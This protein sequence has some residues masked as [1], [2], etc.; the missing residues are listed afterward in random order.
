M[1]TDEAY[2]QVQ[3]TTDSEDDARRIASTVVGERLAACAQLLAP[4]TSVYW[5][6]GAV[7]EAKEWLC[8]LKTTRD[9]YP[10]LE[11][12][13]RELHSYEEPEI[14]A[15]RLAAGSRG[16]LDWIRASTGPAEEAS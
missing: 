6:D 3:T 13:L 2:L 4:V 14:V 8:L 12:R 9:R 5:W 10:A 1:S 11:A 16:Y 7:T 15:V